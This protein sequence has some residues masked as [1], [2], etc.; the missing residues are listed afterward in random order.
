MQRAQDWE[1]EPYNLE[2]K[3]TIQQIQKAIRQQT[4]MMAEKNNHRAI[5][6]YFKLVVNDTYS[7]ITCQPILVNNF[8]LKPVLINMMQ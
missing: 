4:Y 8:K 3:R 1:L 6:D 2:I 5:R 7:S